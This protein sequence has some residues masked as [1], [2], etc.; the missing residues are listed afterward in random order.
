MAL[1]HWQAINEALAGANHRWRNN[2][3]W[4]GYYLPNH[5]SPLHQALSGIFAVT[6]EDAPVFAV[7]DFDGEDDYETCRF[8]ATVWTETLV[9]RAVRMPDDDVVRVA[10]HPRAELT[11]LTVV[12]APIVFA[13][14]F[15]SRDERIELLLTY[16]GWSATLKQSHGSVLRDLLPSFVQDLQAS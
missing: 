10:V 15:E 5:V 16:P 13:G 9:V 12:R 6:R 7:V 1:E 4:D 3:L 11:G 8:V 14:A 2:V